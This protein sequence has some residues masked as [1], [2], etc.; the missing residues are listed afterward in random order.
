MLKVQC[1]HCQVLGEVNGRSFEGNSKVID[2]DLWRTVEELGFAGS[3]AA[4]AKRLRVD[5][6]TVKRRVETIER[7]LGRQ[8]F[9]RQSGY[10]A[11]TP[12]C[13][14]A[15]DEVR[16]AAKHLELAQSRLTPQLERRMKRK[17]VLTSLTYI[18]DR[19][20]GPA[21]RRLETDPGLRIELVGGD[22]NLDL[23]SER[24]AD[25]A[26][27]LGPGSA[28]CV[29]SWYIADIDYATYISKT[30]SSTDCRWATLDRSHSHLPEVSLPEQHAGDDG[31][32]FTATTMTTLESIIQASA[33]KGI[34]PVFLG[35][36]N[37]QLRR[38]KDHPS[39]VRPLWLLWRDDLMEEPDFGPIVCWIVREA[40][41]C[42]PITEQAR[43][44][45][46]KFEK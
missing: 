39:L 6:T 13:K 18:C 38:L 30:K 10:L 23:S 45:L 15:L 20:L 40:T 36:Q 8:L 26:L 3:Y 21:A 19:L 25:M 12:A 11:P 22:R 14:K 24:A 16:I 5:A 27:R 42:L 4:A 33:A 7:A 46:K 29:S 28:T 32:R 43:D 17:I 31:V 1:L 9:L 41:K 37:S 44:L 35:A 2:W 34:L